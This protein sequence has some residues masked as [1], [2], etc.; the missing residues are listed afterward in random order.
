M[1][2]PAF[3]QVNMIPLRHEAVV[4]VGP[5]VGFQAVLPSHGS[6]WALNDEPVNRAKLAIKGNKR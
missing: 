1:C 5:A 3:G 4:P 6:Q 2:V